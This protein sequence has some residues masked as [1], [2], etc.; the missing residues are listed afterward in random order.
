MSTFLD[1]RDMESKI[2]LKSQSYLKVAMIKKIND[3][4][5]WKGY[6]EKGILLC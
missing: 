1:I 5:F 4:T 2:A 3:D 6:K